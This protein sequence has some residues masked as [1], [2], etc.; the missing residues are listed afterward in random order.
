MNTL[1]GIFLRDLSYYGTGGACSVLYAPRSID[2]LAAAMQDIARRGL[3]WFLLGRGA[4]SLISDEPWSGAVITFVGMRGRRRL[5]DHGI[6]CEA[7]VENSEAARY[8]AELCLSGLEFMYGMPG[9]MGATTRM[10]ARCYGGEM[11][12]VVDRLTAVAPDGTVKT[13]SKSEIF[14]GY[15][16]TIFGDN[17]ET[18]AAIELKLQ[19]SFKDAIL[20]NMDTNLNDRTSRHQFA[21]PSCG[22]VFKNNHDV[23]VS[24]GQLLEACQVK[25]LRIGNAEVSPWHANFIFNKGASSRDI[26]EL[27]LQLREKVYLA[28]GVW[29]EFEMELLG[30]F[31]AELVARVRERRP[32]AVKEEALKLLRTGRN[33]P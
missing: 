20:R 22:C 21:S 1:S 10:N 4:N 24:S 23:G 11:S 3:P 2:E 14:L 12:Q 28:Y 31:P 17:R 7:G 30:N 32:A 16:R 29:M 5:G 27:A 18:I 6:E 19:K 9:Q 33:I 25:G 15:K 8:A 13:Y 26:L